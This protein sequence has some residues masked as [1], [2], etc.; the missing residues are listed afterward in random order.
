MIAL[1][2]VLTFLA[3]ILLDFF[4]TRRSI[5]LADEVVGGFVVAPNLKYHPGHMWAVAESRELVRI[6]I[7]DLAAKVARDVTSI[8]IP[9]RGTW[10]RQGQ[11][12]VAMHRNGSE[13]D[14]V[15][16]IEGTVIGIN[17]EVIA[18]PQL[19]RKDPYGEG[20]LL[21]VNSPDA[22]T[23]FRNLLEG[24]VARRWM[25]EAAATLRNLTTP[26]LVGATMHDG[27][28]ALELPAEQIEKVQKQ[29][30]LA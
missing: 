12:I 14:L 28:E 30:F 15:S 3:G 10:I 22:K 27:G 4:M 1:L 18:N 9:E 16:P 8:D 11:R 7:D 23:N 19:A 5:M 25:E 17:D 21:T 24:R 6:G 2:V 29:L 20:W 13:I 26:S